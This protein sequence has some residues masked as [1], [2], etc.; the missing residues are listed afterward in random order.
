VFHLQR[1][2]NEDAKTEEMKQKQDLLL[3]LFLEWQ[4]SKSQE[5]WSKIQA[6]VDEI[7]EL[8]PGFRQPSPR[9]RPDRSHVG[10]LQQR[11]PAI[12]SAPGASSL[13]LLDT[14]AGEEARFLPIP[15]SPP[16]G[17]ASEA[18]CRIRLASEKETIHASSRCGDRSA[19][20]G[21]ILVRSWAAVD[22]FHPSRHIAGPAGLTRS[23]EAS[24]CRGRAAMDAGCVRRRLHLK[25]SL[26]SA[27][28][29][30]GK[31]IDAR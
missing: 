29:R 15:T 22:T 21:P 27:V 12:A 13:S 24:V 7:K 26:P 8:N 17:S 30:E 1:V 9:H 10:R 20:A 2:V 4:A 6:V 31:Q 28:V 3:D 19:H 11:K 14:R 18:L 5:T 23:C 16:P 25:A